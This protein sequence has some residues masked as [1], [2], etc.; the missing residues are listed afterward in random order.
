M[1]LVEKKTGSEEAGVQPGQRGS[2][3]Q[4]PSPAGGMTRGQ[5]APEPELF[6]ALVFLVPPLIR[7]RPDVRVKILASPLSSPFLAL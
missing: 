6:A 1:G 2:E 4:K 5:D 7:V 3:L